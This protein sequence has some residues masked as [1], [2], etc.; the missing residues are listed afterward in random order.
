MDAADRSPRG[1]STRQKS[2][3]LKLR[4]HPSPDSRRSRQSRSRASERQGRARAL[5]PGAAPSRHFPRGLSSSCAFARPGLLAIL[6]TASLNQYEG[7]LGGMR[8]AAEHGKAITTKRCNY[9]QEADTY[10]RIRRGICSLT[11]RAV[12]PARE[13][14]LERAGSGAEYDA[15][16]I[17]V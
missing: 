4:C 1:G 12:N 2:S 16:R 14:K 13:R 8:P 6:P 7:D 17:G 11:G 5:P 15:C 9:N 10:L 3:L